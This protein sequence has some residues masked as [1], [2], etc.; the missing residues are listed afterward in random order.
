MQIEIKNYYIMISEREELTLKNGATIVLTNGED[1]VTVHI[2][3]FEKPMMKTNN[4]IK[5]LAKDIGRFLRKN[6]GKAFSEDGLFSKVQEQ[7]RDLNKLA[8]RLRRINPEY[9]R[10]DYKVWLWGAD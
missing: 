5:K 7:D 8:I 1:G 3:G 6:Y 9:T 4:D 2:T 10:I